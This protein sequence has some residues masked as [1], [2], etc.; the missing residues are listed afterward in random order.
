MSE[1]HGDPAADVRSFLP[2]PGEPVEDYAH[3]LRVLHRDLTLVLEAVERGLAAASASECELPRPSDDPIEIV[4][5]PRAE[6]QPPDR[7]ASPARPR[8]GA[9]RVEVMP[10][11]SGERGRFDGENDRRA[12]DPPR[13]EADAAEERFQPDASVPRLQP[14]ASEPRRRPGAS[15][16]RLRPGG[17]D[18]RV[19]PGD[20]DPRVRPGAS[21]PRLQ[22]DEVDPRF[23]PD[24][25]DPRFQPDE[26]DPRFQPDEVGPRM[27][28]QE[29]V[30]RPAPRFPS[31]PSGAGEDATAREPEWIDRESPAG[32]GFTPP[33]FP[34]YGSAPSS[35]PA[36]S[37]AIAAALLAAW[38]VVVALLVA[39]LVS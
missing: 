32:D 20:S 17:S 7:E 12:A 24:E 28:P 4:P 19:R 33:L 37:P 15:D 2:R 5:V 1:G 31:R 21:D 39:L 9:P 38:L 27:R 30:P 34:P 16:P 14:G 3:R 18:P 29:R 35:R 10:P 22:P 6:P 23:Q 11:A 13:V 25:V 36:V 26:V 8:G